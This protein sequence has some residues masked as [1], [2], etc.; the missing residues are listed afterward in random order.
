MVQVNT[1]CRCWRRPLHYGMLGMV[2]MAHSPPE[3]IK[4]IFKANPLEAYTPHSLTDQSAF[5]LR[6]EEIRKNGYCIEKEEAI[7]GVFGIAA[8]IMDFSRKIIAAL[9][10]AQ[11]VS[12]GSQKEIQKTILLLKQVTQEISDSLGY[13]KV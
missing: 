13:M 6:M 9:G 11:P 4:E 5:S 3:K 7:E 10:I 2:L 1:G 8:P 12:Q